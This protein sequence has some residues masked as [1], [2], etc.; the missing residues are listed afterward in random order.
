MKHCL[1]AVISQSKHLETPIRTKNSHGKF[2]VDAAPF[3]CTYRP[4][5]PFIINNFGFFDQFFVTPHQMSGQGWR[6]TYRCSDPAAAVSDTQYTPL[7]ERM[8]RWIATM[9]PKLFNRFS[10]KAYR[11]MSSL[12]FEAGFPH[13][14]FIDS[15]ADKIKLRTLSGR[16]RNYRCVRGPLG[17][18]ISSNPVPKQASRRPGLTTIDRVRTGRISK[19]PAGVGIVRDRKGVDVARS[20]VGFY[21][22]G[23]LCYRLSFL[24][25]FLHI[26][27]V[28][29][30]FS[31]QHESCPLAIEECVTCS[32]WSLCYAYWND[33]V[34]EEFPR[35]RR[36]QWVQAFDD[37]VQSTF[38]SAM[39]QAMRDEGIQ[40]DVTEFWSCLFDQLEEER[41][42][43]S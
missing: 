25:C 23:V 3:I 37:A 9:A 11:E 42:D 39:G 31:K 30:Y 29:D 35:H 12:V 15:P 2:E 34:S 4:H 22:S 19:W 36:G 43:E 28:Y 18:N 40:N 5:S 1:A 6:H 8:R 20:P 24:Q 26:P 32:L 16:R 10:L 38:T 21:N 33:R 7:R 13:K 41:E 14:L 27:A 17:R